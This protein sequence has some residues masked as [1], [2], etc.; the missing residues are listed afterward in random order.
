[1][2]TP[3]RECICIHQGAWI[4]SDFLATTVKIYNYQ[5]QEKITGKAEKE[6]KKSQLEGRRKMLREIP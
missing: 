6:K 1:M 2:V 4:H 3:K 5:K